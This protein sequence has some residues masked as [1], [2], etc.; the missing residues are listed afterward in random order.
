M[1]GMD[2][3]LYHISQNI[4]ADNKPTVQ[5]SSNWV[6]IS[7]GR[8]KCFGDPVVARNADGG[9][10]VFVLFSD[11]DNQVRLGS[12]WQYKDNGMLRWSH[13]GLV[14][15]GNRQWSP[16]KRPA[17]APNP[18][19]ILEVFMIG[20]DKK[21]YHTWQVPR[22]RGRWLPDWYQFGEEEWPRGS[23]PSI[24]RTLDG[25]IELFLR[26][27]DGKY[28]HR[29]ET[30]KNTPDSPPPWFWSNWTEMP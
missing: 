23:N 9:L 1:I 16:R 5:W 21:L 15:G 18:D 30:S 11:W 3:K 14:G 28:H 6:Q 4:V 22:S 7:E 8:T 24:T 12:F 17:V 13:L 25:R 10:E 27:S 19:G 29:W 20:M 2:K 26:S